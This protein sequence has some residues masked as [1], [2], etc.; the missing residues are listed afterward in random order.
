MR[1]DAMRPLLVTDPSVELHGV[2]GL[3]LLTCR[4]Y[5]EYAMTNAPTIIRAI[6]QPRWWNRRAC[7]MVP[8]G[9]NPLDQGRRRPGTA[10]DL[11]R[12]GS[13]CAYARRNG[14]VIMR[15]LSKTLTRGG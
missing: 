15:A 4:S 13:T 14:L 3:A 6:P 1:C 5:S 9:R 10:S 2:V 8:A 11:S 7:D 12:H